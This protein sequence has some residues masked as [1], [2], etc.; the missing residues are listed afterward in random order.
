MSGLGWPLSVIPA[1]LEPPGWIAAGLGIAVWGT[2]V[3]VSAASGYVLGRL[4]RNN[5]AK[6]AAAAMFPDETGEKEM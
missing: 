6:K 5:A 4:R 3:G 2:A 1:A